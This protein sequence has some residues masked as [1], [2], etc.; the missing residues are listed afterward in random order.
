M[1][2]SSS[3]GLLRVG[4]EGIDNYCVCVSEDRPSVSFLTSDLINL[5]F[6]A[7][8]HATALCRVAFDLI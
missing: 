1:M 3:A 7:S 8:E 4:F 5:F 6:I 2:M